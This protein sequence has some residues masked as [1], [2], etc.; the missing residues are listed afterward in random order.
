LEKMTDLADFTYFTAGSDE[1]L[2]YYV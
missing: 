1:I 2:P